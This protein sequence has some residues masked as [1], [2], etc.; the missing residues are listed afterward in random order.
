MLTSPPTIKTTHMFVDIHAPLSPNPDFTLT[1]LRIFNKTLSN[2]RPISH[3]SFI[4]KLNERVV[5][6]RINNCLTSNSLLNP[7][8]SGFTKRHSVETPLTSL[9]NKLVSAISHRQ[10]SCL[11]IR[12]TSAA[13]DTIDHNIH[14]LLKRVSA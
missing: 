10:V 9:Y 7:Q 4:S 6:S 5:L 14:A 12:D 3:L 2:Y 11:C 1:T 13:F 8:Q